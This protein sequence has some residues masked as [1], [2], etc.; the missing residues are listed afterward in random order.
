MELSIWKSKI[1]NMIKD[2]QITSNMQKISSI[3]Q[4]ILE[5]KQILEILDLKGRN[6]IWPCAPKVTLSFPD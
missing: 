6:H 3:H 2:Y 1:Q 4:F 5:M